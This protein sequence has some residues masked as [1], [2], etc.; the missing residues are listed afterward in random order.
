MAHPRFA[1]VHEMGGRVGGNG[2]ACGRREY[3]RAMTAQSVLIF[4]VCFGLFGVLTMF[5]GA[6]VPDGEPALFTGIAMMLAALFCGFVV[7]STV[8]RI[9]DVDDA[10]AHAHRAPGA[11]VEVPISGMWSTDGPLLKRRVLDELVPPDGPACVTVRAVVM[12]RGADGE[13][14]LLHAPAEAAETITSAKGLVA[15]SRGHGGPVRL[16]IAGTGPAADDP[17]V[18]PGALVEVFGAEWRAAPACE[19]VEAVRMCRSSDNTTLVLAGDRT[20]PRSEATPA[21]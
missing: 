17:Q 9:A 2:R 10:V 4:A 15:H 3:V 11:M 19:Q 16:P 20:E 8:P 6:C 5:L 14:L 13:R 21:P 12:C 7:L 18:A 1:H